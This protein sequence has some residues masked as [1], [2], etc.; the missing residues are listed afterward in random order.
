[1]NGLKAQGKQL[2]KPQ[3]NTMTEGN[4]ITKT[5]TS[6]QLKDLAIGLKK[7]E[8][9]IDGNVEG[10]AKTALQAIWLAF[11]QGDDL[12]IAKSLCKHG[13]FQPWVE[14]NFPKSYDIAWRYMKMASIPKIER[15]QFLNNPK[16]I[17]EIYR[18]LGI[19]PPDES[20]PKEIGSVT[21]P[22]EIQ[23]LNWLAEWFS[24]NQPKFEEMQETERQELKF[25]L[26]PIA[27]IYELL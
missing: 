4:Q 5:D 26:K 11:E 8:Q 17:N 22:P 13:A 2:N 14:D 24:K 3:Q 15:I 18:Q 12:L 16:T 7:R 9:E 10:A 25:K 19:L 21:I 20:K 23:K 1:M 27:E 6:K